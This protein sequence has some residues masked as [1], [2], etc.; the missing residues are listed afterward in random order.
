MSKFTV[1]PRE[2]NSAEE[3]LDHFFKDN[4]S[5]HLYKEYHALGGGKAGSCGFISQKQL[6]GRVYTVFF[7]DSYLAIHFHDTVFIRDVKNRIPHNT[8][9]SHCVHV[10]ITLPN[11]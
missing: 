3:C 4:I 11:N 9:N 10:R 8:L 5:V 7:L 2:W 1:Y 6:E